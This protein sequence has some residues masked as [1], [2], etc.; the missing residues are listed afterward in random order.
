M[1]SKVQI[2][3]YYNNASL[4]ILIIT[5]KKVTLKVI[6]QGLLRLYN[7]NISFDLTKNKVLFMISIGKVSFNINNLT[8]HLT[9]NIPIQQSLFNLLNLSSYSLNR[10]TCRYEQLQLLVIDEI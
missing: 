7:K 4:I 3:I 5:M 2:P 9:F 1:N 6:I 10:F 8:I